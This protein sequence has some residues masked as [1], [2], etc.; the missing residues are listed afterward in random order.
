MLYT[1]LTILLHL[2]SS[3]L[4]LQDLWQIKPVGGT[5]LFSAA[6]DRSQGR[7]RSTRAVASKDIAGIDL[8]L[9]FKRMDLL[10]DERAIDSKH[11]NIVKAMRKIDG[12]G[13]KGGIGPI[14]NAVASYL[15]ERVLSNED[16][17]NDPSWLTAPIIVTGNRERGVINL[18]QA[19]RWAAL[20][21]VPVVRWRYPFDLAIPQ[22]A[23]DTT[24]KAWLYQHEPDLTGLFV[25]GAVAYL[26]ADEYKPL[27]RGFQRHPS[28]LRLPHFLT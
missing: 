1:R 20:H 2:L 13:V 25:Q 7:L 3:S 24:I 9:D 18:Q 11:A 8:F 17:R 14:T 22:Y 23:N 16:V 5:A 6:L 26:T 28:H 10:I 4:P 15:K 21:G 12:L 19:K 27:C